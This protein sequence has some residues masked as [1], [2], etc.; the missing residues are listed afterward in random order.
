MPVGYYQDS[1]G[2]QHESYDAACA[3]YGVDS[4]AQLAAEDAAMKAEYRAEMEAK[5]YLFSADGND[6][7]APD[8]AEELNDRK[9]AGEVQP[10]AVFDVSMELDDDIPF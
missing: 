4:P 8:Y 10:G 3:Y 2:I 7:M 5:G 1:S 6:M 9:M